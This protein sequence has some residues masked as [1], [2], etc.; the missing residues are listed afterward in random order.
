MR[1]IVFLDRDTLQATIRSPAFAHAWVDYPSTP[2][3]Q[4]VARLVGAHIAITNKVPIDARALAQL[5]QLEM[6]AVAATGTDIVDLEACR[7]RGVEVR[8]V[9]GYGT[10]AVAEHT[11]MLA[12]VLIRQ[13]IAY[14]CRVERGDW[15]SSPIFCLTQPTIREIHGSSVGIIGGGQIGTRV[16][17]LFAALGATVLFAERKAEATVRP[18]RVAFDHVL[19]RAD[20]L[21]LH[22]PLTPETHHLV[23][24]AELSRMKPSSLLINTARGALIDAPALV[25]ALD[26]GALGGAAVD[27]LETEPPPAGHP[28]LTARHPNLL[29][30][31][32]CAWASQSAQQTLADRVVDNLEAFVQ[33]TRRSTGAPSTPK[34]EAP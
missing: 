10:N 3:Q 17:E 32:H 20:I 12:L 18:G 33:G 30:T 28:L 2:P 16:G 1:R 13:L 23:G 4:V 9:R 26:S 31:P 21:T 6:I 15:S 19:E 8:N 25:R 14:R 27:V 7:A 29:V 24:R 22:C 5:S 34:S 11:V